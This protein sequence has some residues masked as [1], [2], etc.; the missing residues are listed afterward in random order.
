M[1]VEMEKTTQPRCRQLPNFPSLVP[2]TSIQC[3]PR[4]GTPQRCQGGAPTER[5]P[6][7]AGAV[8]KNPGQAGEASPQPVVQ[9][10]ETHKTRQEPRHH[11]GPSIPLSP[12][13][14]GRP[15]HTTKEKRVHHQ[16][17]S[18]PGPRNPPDKPGPLG[19]M[20]VPACAPGLQIP[21]VHPGITQIP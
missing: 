2:P 12:S 9:D 6:H 15:A 14:H 21:T 19:T 10:T 11:A 18:S 1:H 17:P 3:C 7:S 20:Q 5:L 8:Y 4:L 13:H 16:K